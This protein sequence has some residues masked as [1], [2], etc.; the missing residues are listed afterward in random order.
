MSQTN[1][2]YL[3][4]LKTSSAARFRPNEAFAIGDVPSPEGPVRVVLQTRYEDIG[5]EAPA[6][7]ELW[8]EVAGRASSLD[9]AISA[10]SQAARGFTSILSFVANAPVD[11]LDFHLGYDATPGI[12]KREFTQTFL[13]DE[14]GLVNQ[15][16]LVE[17]DLLKAFVNAVPTNPEFSRLGRALG[18]YHLALRN[19]FFGGETLALAHLFIA[20]EVLTKAVIR[21]HCKKDSVDEQHLAKS[22]GIRTDEPKWRSTLEAWHRANSIFQGDTATYQQAKSASDGLEHGFMELGEVHD[23]ARK[24]TEKTFGYVRN[25]IIAVAEIA[26]DRARTELQKIEPLDVLSFRKMVRG[27]FIGNTETLAAPGQA[28]P[29]LIWKSAVRE[30]RWN[31][32]GKLHASFNETFTVRSAEGLGFQGSAFAVYGRQQVGSPT[33]VEFS[34]PSPTGGS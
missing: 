1:P 28:Y 12:E 23:L 30:L 16:R 10:F 20:V 24:A 15:G 14:R 34:A 21:Q 3:I 9:A 4:V 7:R 33:Q 29:H 13:R 5:L 2:D 19:W 26:D 8:V 25:A 6:P 22:L 31:A 27:Y 32:E 11:L 17:K 18:H